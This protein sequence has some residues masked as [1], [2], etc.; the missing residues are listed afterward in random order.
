MFWSTERLRSERVRLH[1]TTAEEERAI[2]ARLEPGWEDTVDA[3]AFGAGQW[4]LSAIHPAF[5]ATFAAVHVRQAGLGRDP[6]SGV[7]PGARENDATLCLEVE[8]TNHVGADGARFGATVRELRPKEPLVLTAS[9]SCATGA[10][11][12]RASPT[13]SAVARRRGQATVELVG[14]ALVLAVLMAGLGVAAVRSGAAG[15][16]VSA[17]A[18]VLG[19]AEDGEPG[20]P[21]PQLQAATLAEALAAARSEADAFSLA[22]ARALL[23]EELGPALAERVLAGL[24]E[25]EARRRAPAW[26]AAQDRQVD[27]GL[28]GDVRVAAAA[29]RRCRCTW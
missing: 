6:G 25:A 12:C 16:L 28:L 1:V 5:A 17:V 2:A 11:W 13:R 10:S 15:A 24:V 4:V 29:P 14:I 8:R 27:G 3:V 26:F 19:A 23:A 20:A 18:R 7:P 9:R 21:P 22:G